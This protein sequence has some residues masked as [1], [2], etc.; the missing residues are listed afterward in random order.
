VKHRIFV[1][2]IPTEPEASLT[3]TGEEHHHLTRVVRVR[4]GETVEV[5]DAKGR[6]ALARV[7]A[8]GKAECSLELLDAVPSRE[9]ANSLTMAVALIQPEKFEFM[10][11]K[12]T[13]LGAAA[14]IPIVA[15]RTE[16]TGE[17][18][19]GKRDRWS[20]I[21]LEAVKQSGRSHLP[22][23]APPMLF[24]ELLLRANVVLFDADRQSNR[25]SIHPNA[26]L[27]IGPEGGWSENELSAASAANVRFRRLGPRRLR[28]ETAAIAALTLLQSEAGELS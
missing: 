15:E 13:E 14:F 3:V 22:T 8:V 23:L 1:P 19:E 4:E 16:I 12:C 28:A 20:K 25:D 21:I 24:A 26:T 18:A 10:L 2:A 9:A 17:R 7:V 5:F 27:A 11:Q 6:Q